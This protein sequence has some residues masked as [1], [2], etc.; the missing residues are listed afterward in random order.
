MTPIR[1]RP[2]VTALAF[3]ALA[4]GCAMKDDGYKAGDL[5]N[6]GF[7]FSCEDAVA[8][9]RY[10]NDA[11]KFPKKVSLGSTFSVRFEPKSSSKGLA[12]TFN[13]S[14]PDRGIT[15]RAVGDIVSKGPRGMVGLKP[16]FAT[17]ASRD[18]AG[19]I[20]D[21]TVIEVARPDA[22]VIYAADEGRTDPSQVGT[23]ARIELGRGDRRTFRAFARSNK[24][25]LAGSLNVEWRSTDPSVIDVESTTDGKA[26][27]VARAPGQATLI[28]TGGTFEQKIPVE[29]AQ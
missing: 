29:V 5:G 22:L 1:M 13:E 25:D 4:S 3:A 28:A 11:S 6:G 12:I 18:A 7:Y 15:V 14:A 19:A 2:F 26:S 20:V 8:C 10:S 23:V 9:S 24:E 16:G 17:L 27:V 21:Y